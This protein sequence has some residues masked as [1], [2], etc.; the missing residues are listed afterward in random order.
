ME[1]VLSIFAFIFC[2][3]YYALAYVYLDKDFLQKVWSLLLIAWLSYCFCDTLYN[4][5]IT[6]WYISIPCICLLPLSLYSR[7]KK[8]QTLA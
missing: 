5:V 6:E 3:S 2:L 1:Y 7:W 8:D 4:G